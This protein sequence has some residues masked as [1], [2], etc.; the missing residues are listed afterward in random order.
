MEKIEL[1]EKLRQ[2]SEDIIFFVKEDNEAKTL[3]KLDEMIKDAL[4]L[5]KLAT[6]CRTFKFTDD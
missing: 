1:A 5:N 3:Q 4:R 2:I 6:K